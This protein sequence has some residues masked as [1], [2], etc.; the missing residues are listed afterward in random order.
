MKQKMGENSS[1]VSDLT[2]CPVP[3]VALTPLCS[4]VENIVVLVGKVEISKQD[5]STSEINTYSSGPLMLIST[6]NLYIRPPVIVT[7]FVM[8]FVAV[9]HC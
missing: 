9:Y 5:M 1:L 8:A 3:R 4:D 2:S 7:E 6:I